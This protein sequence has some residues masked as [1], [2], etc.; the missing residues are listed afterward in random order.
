MARRGPRGMACLRRYAG[1]A[2]T[3]V[4]QS[5]ECGPRRQRPASHGE[6]WSWWGR[7][8]AGATS[9]HWMAVQQRLFSILAAISL[10]LCVTVLAVWARG[11][12]W[13]QGI[14]HVAHNGRQYIETDVVCVKG[15][16]VC[17]RVALPPGMGG[18]TPRGLHWA[19]E[20]PANDNVLPSVSWW[21]R[22]GFSLDV[23]DAN[24]WMVGLPCW[25]VAFAAGLPATVWLRCYRQSRLA[26][27]DGLCLTCGYDL[28]ANKD[29]CPECGTP[30]PIQS[31]S[32]RN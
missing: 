28:R 24:D 21:N 4:K 19:K 20:T 17:G 30:I 12:W 29:R 15:T 3:G 13:S 10:L 6:R 25:L 22:R 18:S 1:F 9:V 23:R 14:M 32:A 16:I 26:R 5:T 27:R 31:Q 7:C 11:H 8:A 2:E